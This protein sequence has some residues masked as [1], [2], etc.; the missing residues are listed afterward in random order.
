MKDKQPKDVKLF[1]V[2]RSTP[3]AG[4][5]KSPTVDMK[6]KPQW[7]PKPPFAQHIIAAVA[8]GKLK[9]AFA[10]SKQDDIKTNE[11]AP[12]DSRVLVIAS[13]EFLTNPFAYAGNGPDLG[14]QFA[15]MGSVGGDQQLQMFA[16]PYA[17]R[18][19]TNTIISVKNT[20]DWMSGD[21][22]LLAASAKILQDP[23][24]TYS[25]VSKP[26]IS[27]DDDDAAIKKKDEEYREARKHVQRQVQWSLILGVPLLFAAF[28][29]LRWRS[30][31]GRS[32]KFKV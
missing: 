1:A 21:A 24:L 23:N 22:D 28:G 3:V 18:Y 29:L 9:S 5:D 11:V 26:K 16:G 30:R 12:K 27:A 32:D 25:S 17:Q 20:L 10:G 8:E 15:M 14:G 19:L 6:L 2:A 4:V 13:S 31:L 7:N